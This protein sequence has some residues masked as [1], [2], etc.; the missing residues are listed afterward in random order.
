M[1]E[2]GFMLNKLKMRWLSCECH[3]E[4]HF[5]ISPKRVRW[6]SKAREAEGGG[7]NFVILNLKANS[8]YYR[9][10]LFFDVWGWGGSSPLEL[11][12]RCDNGWMLRTYVESPLWLVDQEF[13]AGPHCLRKYK[14]APFTPHLSV[15]EC[16]NGRMLLWAIQVPKSPRIHPFTNA[17]SNSK[18]ICLTN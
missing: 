2:C 15:N 4:S 7:G 17:S 8:C 10:V 12:I 9:P 3:E 16:M 11:F 5:I 13:H 6:P 14:A 1:R 18:H